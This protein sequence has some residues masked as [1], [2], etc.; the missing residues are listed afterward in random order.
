MLY[1]YIYIGELM[2]YLYIYK[3]N[4]LKVTICLWTVCPCSNFK[5]FTEIQKKYPDP[6]GLNQKFL[7]E[8]MPWKIFILHTAVC[9]RGFVHFYMVRPDKK[10]YNTSQSNS[11]LKILIFKKK[12][13]SKI[14]SNVSNLKILYVYTI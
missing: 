3:Y 13:Y 1:R 7:Y 6:G 8:F 12:E 10:T 4:S 9:Q 11:I 14:T 2:R 5:R